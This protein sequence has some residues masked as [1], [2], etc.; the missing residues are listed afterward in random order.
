MSQPPNRPHSAPAGILRRQRR[1]RQQQGDSL[2]FGMPGEDGPHLRNLFFTP[3]ISMAPR[4]C[5][6]FDGWGR[7]PM[8]GSETPNIRGKRILIEWDA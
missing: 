1:L 6:P 2:R 5:P 3:T 4:R 7:I 8:K